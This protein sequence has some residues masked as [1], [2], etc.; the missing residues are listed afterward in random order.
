MGP[1]EVG[2][3]LGVGDVLAG[4]YRL[5]R[6]LGV[7]STAATFGAT[8]RN[9]RT[10]TVKVLH[11]H[12][13]G[14]SSARQRLLREAYLANQ[15]DHPSIVRVLDDG[16]TEGGSLYLVLEQL[17][18]ENLEVT[19]MR[20]GGH[21]A[22]ADVVRVGALL[23]DALH[24]VHEA[25]IVHRDVCPAALFMGEGGELK[26]LD[27]GSACLGDRQGVITEARAVGSPAFMSPEQALSG[28]SAA[29]P[30]ADQWSAAATLVTMMTGRTVHDFGTSKNHRILAAT[31]TASPVITL[32]HV[33]PA[34]AAVLDRCLAFA[35][36]ERFSSAAAARD[37]WIEAGAPYLTAGAPGPSA[38]DTAGFTPPPAL[39]EMAGRAPAP[40]PRPTDDRVGFASSP[41]EAAAVVGPRS[42]PPPPVM[43]PSAAFRI[44]DIEPLPAPRVRRPAM[45]VALFVLFVIAAFGIVALASW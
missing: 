11:N 39:L 41:F 34:L 42:V 20:S 38:D 12:L 19:R 3:R 26:L 17:E 44:A 6:E 45:W 21:L 16:T 29:G 4:R 25:G 1:S 30:A 36:E 2:A 32:G 10:V 18:G 40:P 37:A 15:V 24:H 28:T 31:R 13:T 33:P 5:D 22:L 8:H 35:P 43:T 23:F 14:D 27:F 7:G 9:G